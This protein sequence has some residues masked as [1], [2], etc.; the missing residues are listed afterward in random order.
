MERHVRRIWPLSAPDIVYYLQI[1]WEKD[2]DLGSGF[3]VTVCN[4]EQAWSGRVSDNQ[5]T[6]EAKEAEMD[7]EKYVDELQQALTTGEETVRNYSF[8]FSKDNDEEV[9]HFSY[10]KLLQDISFKLGSVELRQVLDSTEV[11]KELISY[12]LRCNAE[13]RDKN[14]HLQQENKRLL[15]ERN[16]TL[17]ELE[18]Y[19]KAKEELEQDLYSRF[20]LVLNEK[21]AKIR[22]LQETLKCANMQAEFKSQSRTIA[23]SQEVSVAEEDFDCSTDAENK[24]HA[25]ENRIWSQPSRSTCVPPQNDPIGSSLHDVV[26]IA[27]S[28]KRWHRIPQQKYKEAEAPKASSEKS[29]CPMSSASSII[30]HQSEEEQSQETLPNTVE[31]H[32]LF[33]N[34]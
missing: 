25:S 32:D 17:K 30:H 22:S 19:V 16:Y 31:P 14:E 11:N 10:E 28:R 9:F 7:R 12:V 6:M 21:K 4:G 20:I 23:T 24:G 27:P 33:D 8:D 13:L 1:S 15:C 18:K 5:V 3:T 2:Q 26:D 29:L 34:I